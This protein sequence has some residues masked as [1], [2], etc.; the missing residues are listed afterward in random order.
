MRASHGSG[1]LVA[2]LEA[3]VH[4]DWVG[5]ISAGATHSFNFITRDQWRARTAFTDFAADPRFGGWRSFARGKGFFNAQFIYQESGLPDEVL[6]FNWERYQAATTQVRI[7]AL[8]AE[9]GE[10]V[11]WGRSDIT[12]PEDLFLRIR[13]SSTLPI[14]MPP[15]RIEG[16]VYVDGALGTSGGL[17][18]E[19]AR[20]DGF[21]KFLVVMSQPREYLKRLGRQE[22]LAHRVFRRY[23]AVSEAMAERPVRYNSVRT[24]LFE[25]ER[26]GQAYLFVPKPGDLVEGTERNVERLTASHDAG[27]AQARSEMP[28]IL[29]FL[30]LS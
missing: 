9:T 17:A 1:A 3:G 7:G 16:Q 10:T 28:A 29:E 12:T 23:P 19:A 26:A 18:L 21:E 5:G 11:Y 24:E 13:A 27:K 14:M 20:A 22:R 2:L 25:L 4:L 6:P 8:N 15:V 30:G